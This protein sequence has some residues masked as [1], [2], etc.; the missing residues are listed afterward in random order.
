MRNGFQSE[1]LISVN[2]NYQKKADHINLIF[3]KIDKKKYVFFPSK[4][5]ISLSISST[6]RKN[7]DGVGIDEREEEEE[8][9]EEEKKEDRWLER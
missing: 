2:P 7:W 1:H 9:E 8:E 4:I 3:P 6:T 5:N